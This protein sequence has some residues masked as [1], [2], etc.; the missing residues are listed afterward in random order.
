MLVQIPVSAEAYLAHPPVIELMAI[1]MKLGASNEGLS[2]DPVIEDLVVPGA[3]PEI[4]EALVEVSTAGGHEHSTSVLGVLGDDIDHSVDGICT[5][6]G[7][8]RP[9]DDLDPFNIFEQCVL[10]LPIDA[11]KQWRVKPPATDPY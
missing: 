7:P 5:P 6:D 4:G 3:I 8:A 1:W 11:C 2:V 10:D 9:S